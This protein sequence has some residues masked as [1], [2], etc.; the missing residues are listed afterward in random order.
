[1]KERKEK[2]K[3][4]KNKR[5]RMEKDDFIVFFLREREKRWGNGQ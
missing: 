2:R 5:I 3:I 4:N 1:L